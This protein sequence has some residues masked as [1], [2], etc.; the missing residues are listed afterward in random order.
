MHNT[1]THTHTRHT[2]VRHTH[3]HTHTTHTHT[4]THTTHTHTHTHTQHATSPTVGY[5]EDLRRVIARLKRR[6]PHHRL[7]AAGFS[8]GSNY[9]T[10]FVGEE[11][12]D[13]A[14]DAA[15]GL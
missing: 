6:Y 1:H 13:C 10:K 4:H 14:L 15:G 3:T 9:L 7:V 12:A 8:L 11:G 2:H 5:T